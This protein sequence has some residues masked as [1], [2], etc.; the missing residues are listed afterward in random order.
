MALGVGSWVPGAELGAAVIGVAGGVLL[1]NA[2]AGMFE[3]PAAAITE[4]G[5]DL[6]A[7]PTSAADPAARAAAEALHG[8]HGAVVGYALVTTDLTAA[9]DAQDQ[10]ASARELLRTTARTDAPTGFLNRRGWNEELGREVALNVWVRPPDLPR[11]G[12]AMEALKASMAWARP[13]RS[14]GCV[15]I[16]RLKGARDR[17][18]HV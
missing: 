11:A 10:A 12:F 2:I 7:E 13:R 17:K 4:A 1:G 9:K 5:E 18:A 8:E 14:S 15:R 16:L 3:D 6:T